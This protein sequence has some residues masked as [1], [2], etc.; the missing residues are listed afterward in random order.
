MSTWAVVALIIFVLGMILGNIM[1]LKYSAKS[2]F[3]KPS[4]VKSDPTTNKVSP[5]ETSSTDDSS[6]NEY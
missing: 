4:E 1:L 6:K 5:I 2:K 3:E